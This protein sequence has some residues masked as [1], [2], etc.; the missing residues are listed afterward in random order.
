MK[1]INNDCLF[2]NIPSNRIINENKFAYV[3]FDKYPVT[4]FH[5]LIIPKRHFENYFDIDESEIK[6][7]NDLLSDQRNK[8]LEEDNS[9]TGFNIGVNS[10][11]DAGQTIHALSYSFNSKKER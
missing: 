8:I 11:K 2:C 5:S 1:N 3:I 7:V 4:K 9:V 6:A 10:G